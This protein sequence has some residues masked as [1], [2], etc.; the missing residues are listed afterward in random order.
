M[1]FSQIGLYNQALSATGSK[2]RVADTS[3]NSREAHLCN[4]W[5]DVIRQTVIKSAWWPSA[6]WVSSLALLATRD[7]N[8][9]WAEGDPMPTFMYTHKAPS[10]MLAPRHLAD[11][12]RFE[13]GIGLD[14]ENDVRAIFSNKSTVVLTYTR[15]VVDLS[16]WDVGLY[17]AIMKTLGAALSRPLTGKSTLSRELLQEALLDIAHAQSEVANQS[18]M[19]QQEMADWHS[20]RGYDMSDALYRYTFPLETLQSLNI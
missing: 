20:V 14:A 2:G 12:S 9:D 1:A 5:Y 8:L 16:L 17:N 15:D 13:Q 10:D 4:Q 7:F 18:N 6:R 11:F 3:E 19:V